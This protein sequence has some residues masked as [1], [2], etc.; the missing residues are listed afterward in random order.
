ME[1]LHFIKQFD[2]MKTVLCNRMSS[3]KGMGNMMKTMKNFKDNKKI[4]III[5]YPRMKK[6]SSLL[7]IIL[8]AVSA[9]DRK[10]KPTCKESPAV[11]IPSQLL[12]LLAKN[13]HSPPEPFAKTRCNSSEM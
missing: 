5:I 9:A 2:Q 6:N 3:G 13:Y 11:S 10:L 8:L 4:Y 12:N 7:L 1:L